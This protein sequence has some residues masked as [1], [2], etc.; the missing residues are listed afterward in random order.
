M[1]GKNLKRV[2]QVAIVV[3][4]IE[5]TTAVWSELL[6]VEKPKISETEG[7][8]ST[9]MK[10][11]GKPSEGKAK[12]AFINMENLVLEFIQPVGGPSTWQ[13]FLEKRGEGIHH[14]TFNV[15]NLEETLRKLREIGVKPEQIGDFEGGCY[16]YT[17]AKSKLGA[18]I[19]LL[20]T[21]EY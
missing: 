18:I 17:D 1:S 11:R 20:H 5:K 9:Y 2:T 12:L 13:G 16:V 7:P 3:R 8:E 14:I 21:Q 4:D 10:F 19:E 15:E 6:G